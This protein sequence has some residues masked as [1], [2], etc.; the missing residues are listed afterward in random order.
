VGSSPMTFRYSSSFSHL[1]ART[2]LS[3]ILSAIPYEWTAAYA[4]IEML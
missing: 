1:S 2:A 3:A 4:T